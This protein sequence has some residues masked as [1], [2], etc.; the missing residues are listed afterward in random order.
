MISTRA[1]IITRRTYNRPIDDAGTVFETWEQT[2][3]RVI[4]H[5][6]WL[7]ARAKGDSLDDG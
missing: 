3:D 5:Q 1:E 6:A 2:V 7:W 4:E